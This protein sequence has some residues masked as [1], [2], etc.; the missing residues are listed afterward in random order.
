[1]RKART[2]ITIEYGAY[3]YEVGKQRENIDK[4]WFD[5][6]NTETHQN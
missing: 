1:M 4:S 3:G 5:I 2:F 6:L